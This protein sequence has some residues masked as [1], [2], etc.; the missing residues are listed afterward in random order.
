MKAGTTWLYT[1]LSRHKQLLFAPEKEIHYFYYKFV[2][3][4]ILSDQRRLEKVNKFLKRIDPK[5]ANIQHSNFIIHWLGAYVSRPIDDYWYRNLFHF[6]RSQ[7]YG[8][9]FSN[10]Q[11]L[12]PAEAWQKISSICG[13]LKVVYT[14]RRPIDRMWSHIKYSL[15]ALDQMDRLA[16]WGPKD[17]EAFC[18]RPHMW[19]HAEYGGALRRMKAGLGRDQFKALFFED[20]R[21]SPH[22]VLSEIE[23]FLGVTPHKYPDRLISRRVNE[24]ASHPMPAFL[25]GLF[26]A[27]FERI[28]G[29]VEKEGLVI[30]GSWREA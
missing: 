7:I 15:S 28:T 14:M 2:D 8:C 29:E 6:D 13:R 5:R 18:R 11:A 12:L 22:E 26:A 30:P 23:S 9:D 10:L 21:N 16:T 3:P 19:N 1:M 27:D 17:F 24:T 20:A 4:Q 25:P